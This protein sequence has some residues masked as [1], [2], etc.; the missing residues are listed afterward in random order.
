MAA[1]MV[2]NH[3]GIDARW[4][5]EHP[6]RFISTTRAAVP[7][8]LVHR[9]EPLAGQPGRYPARG[10]LLGRH[11]RRG[12]LPP[13]RHPEQ[14]GTV[15]LPRE[16]RHLVPLE[17][18]GPARLPPRR[19]PRSGH[20]DDPGRGPPRADPPLR[21]RDGPRAQAHPATLVP[22]AGCR[23]GDP[24]TR[25]AR[26]RERGVQ[27][28]N[29]EG[30]LARGRRPGRRRRA[31]DA[32]PRGGVLAARGLLRADPRDAP[33]LQ[34]GLHAHAPRRGQ[35]GLPQGHARDARVRPG[36]PRAGS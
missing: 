8:V 22:G 18:H 23:R 26:A 16:R 28:A 12:R 11:G 1:D 7:R 5:I 14:R 4:V 33:R 20:P 17:R 25:R 24:L 10:P 35:R 29:A 27:Q 6:E 19:R 31:G 13:T 21:R 15:H 34:L 3:M 36:D 32:A 2:P 30:V 9:S